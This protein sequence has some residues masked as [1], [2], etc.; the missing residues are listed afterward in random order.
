MNIR[1]EQAAETK[2]KIVEAA[3]DILSVNGPHT[4]TSGKLSAKLGM[5]KGTLFHH[6]EDME[7]V[8]LA[9]L[10]YIIALLDEV[11]E[12]NHKN[13]Q[14]LVNDLIDTT[15]T[16]IEQYRG[17]YAA[18]FYF[19]SNSVHNPACQERLRERINRTMAA[20]KQTLFKHVN[21]EVSDMEQDRIVRM[22]DVFF[23]GLCIHDFIYTDPKRY[24]RITKD[25]M[26]I[27]VH[28]L[29]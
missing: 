13:L 2:Q 20:W 4:L 16:S 17:V 26:A 21:R 28:H 3:V 27:M 6:F 23:S 7:E 11:Q 10:D 8:Q 22:L 5:S 24:K 18:L 1:V 25:F 12:R 9:V 19:I 14:A 15:F 29:E